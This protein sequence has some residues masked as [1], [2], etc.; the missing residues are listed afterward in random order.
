MHFSILI[1]YGSRKLKR[2]MKNENVLATEAASQNATSKMKT[3]LP[4]KP[5]AKTQNVK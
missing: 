3:F 2:N 4:R 1:Y 5:Q